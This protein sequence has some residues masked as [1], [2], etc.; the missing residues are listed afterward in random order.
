MASNGT[1]MRPSFDP[2]PPKN[3]ALHKLMPQCRKNAQSSPS[4]RAEIE[5][6]SVG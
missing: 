4:R 6:F 1:R 2:T 5:D 3:F